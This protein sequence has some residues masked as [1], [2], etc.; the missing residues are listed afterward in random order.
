MVGDISMQ[1][2]PTINLSTLV[3]AL[4]SIHV[5]FVKRLVLSNNMQSIRVPLYIVLYHQVQ[6]NILKRE[7]SLIQ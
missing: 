4:H 1:H 2:T 6:K 3:D 5:T 7:L